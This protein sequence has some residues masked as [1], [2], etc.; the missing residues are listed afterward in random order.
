MKEYQRKAIKELKKIIAAHKLLNVSEEIDPN[1]KLKVPTI[2]NEKSQK[3]IKIIVDIIL[4][5]KAEYEDDNSIISY[6]PY[7]E[8][9]VSNL[10]ISDNEK[11]NV[12]LDLLGPIYKASKLAP[13]LP[14]EFFENIK[15]T[16]L[17]LEKFQEKYN[18]L[19]TEDKLKEAIKTDYP[20]YYNMILDELD[21]SKLKGEKVK[22]GLMVF[23]DLVIDESGRPTKESLP[24]IRE[25]LN[26]ISLKPEFIEF[27]MA[28][29]KKVSKNNS[30]KPKYTQS[31]EK[32]KKT[33]Q[34]NFKLKVEPTKILTDKEWKE[35][36]EEINQYYDLQS[37][38][39]KRCLDIIE[40]QRLINLLN[41][42]SI[43]NDEIRKI[44]WE[45]DHNGNN[46]ITSISKNKIRT[47]IIL[48]EIRKK[49]LMSVSSFEL[50]KNIEEI[51]NEYLTCEKRDFDT[52]SELLLEEII[53]ENENGKNIIIWVEKEIHGT[54]YHQYYFW[55]E[56]LLKEKGYDQHQSIALV[57]ILL[58]LIRNSKT[59]EE[60][61]SWKKQ[62]YATFER[63]QMEQMGNNDYEM[64]YAER[65]RKR[66][67]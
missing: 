38:V 39:V 65:M 67:K 5:L 1:N 57:N 36:E 19:K 20:D 24:K 43:K 9:I 32:P 27:I 28:E 56:T 2:L 13:Y 42:L 55:K 34:S 66:K 48:N 46:H 23:K 11:L 26:F 16:G 8:M 14:S 52:W 60:K 54:A 31:L 18:T 61:N 22:Q 45:I 6:S 37:K 10:K 62:L 17:T 4:V 33:F 3:F 29:L 64:I 58:Y 40:K 44:L 47:G 7:I 21:K 50:P 25:A 35:I 59:K 53:K 41:N 49:A 12:F 63:M 51:F 15:C 30:S